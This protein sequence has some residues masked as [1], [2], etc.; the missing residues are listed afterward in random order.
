MERR[1]LDL[2]KRF[3]EVYERLAPSFGYETRQETRAF[4]PDS[5][6]GKLMT[7]V[8][9]EIA[10]QQWHDPPILPALAENETRVAY[11][12][13]LKCRAEHLRREIASQ[14]TMLE[15]EQHAAAR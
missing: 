5:A 13:R 12:A 11:I 9:A 14:E 3:H 4:D 8:C 15:Q 1:G 2:A 7:A 6:N 10:G